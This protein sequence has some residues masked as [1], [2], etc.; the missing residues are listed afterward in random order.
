MNNMK[1]ES[2]GIKNPGC[3]NNRDLAL[4]THSHHIHVIKGEKAFKNVKKNSP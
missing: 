4:E 3:M 2:T 1:K